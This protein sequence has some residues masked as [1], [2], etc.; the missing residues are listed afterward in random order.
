[1]NKNSYKIK[2]MALFLV[3]VLTL[4]PLTITAN[5]INSAPL[6]VEDLEVGVLYTAVWDYTDRKSTRLNSSHAT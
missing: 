1:M 2:L 3:L 4:S 6:S 5:A